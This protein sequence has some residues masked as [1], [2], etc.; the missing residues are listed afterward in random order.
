MYNVRVHTVQLQIQQSRYYVLYNVKMFLVKIRL[1]IIVYNRTVGI[2]TSNFGVF[3]PAGS[4]PAN[5]VNIY[6]YNRI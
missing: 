1:Y 6:N 5:V 3:D 2:Q 4:S